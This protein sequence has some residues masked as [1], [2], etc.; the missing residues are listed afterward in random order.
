MTTHLR[1]ADEVQG[2]HIVWE[3]I[4]VQAQR[5]ERIRAYSK[6]AIIELKIYMA[7]ELATITLESKV[8]VDHL[9]TQEIKN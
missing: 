3:V 9:Q 5:W 1:W 6:E 8:I 2:V 7:Q 4:L